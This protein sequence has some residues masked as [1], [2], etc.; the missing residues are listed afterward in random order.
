[1]NHY[2]ALIH[3]DEGSAYGISFPDLPAIFSAADEEDNLA[4]QA[5]DAL[6]LWAEDEAMPPPSA[7]GE[8]LERPDIRKK[9]A[10]GAFLMRIPFIEDSTRIVRANVTFEKGMLDAIDTAAK[11]RGLT[12]SAF[13]S[14]C[15]RKEIEAA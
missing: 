15:A 3:K 2:M 8:L 14:S 10:A 1:M 9:L 11:E 4:A 12:R 5:I 6:R 7:H 13:L